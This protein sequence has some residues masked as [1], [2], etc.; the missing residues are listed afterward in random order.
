MTS[1]F[2]RSDVQSV[3]EKNK[4]STLRQIRRD[5]EKKLCLGEGDLDPYKDDI[6]SIILSLLEEDTATDKA[7]NEKLSPKTAK[8]DE[9]SS[10]NSVVEGKGRGEE[11]AEFNKSKK[12]KVV[13]AQDKPFK[14]KKKR[15]Y[16][17]SEDEEPRKSKHSKQKKSVQP[18]VE[19][20]QIH[21][22]PT[23]KKLKA[24]AKKATIP[25]PPN[26]FKSWKQHGADATTAA[27]ELGE[28]LAEKAG[29]GGQD[30]LAL[31]ERKISNIRNR[32]ERERD[33][34][35]IDTTNIL[36]GS[37]RRTSKFSVEAIHEKGSESEGSGN[38]GVDS[39]SDSEQNLV[40]LFPDAD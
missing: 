7:K 13:G 15:I 35:D 25:I 11:G 33:L 6:K 23:I 2:K 17:D 14:K 40:E 37:R 8:C 12:R 39:G 3:Y 1:L 4:Q 9:T 22:D 26:V 20:S 5:L 24:F 28:Y 32:L 30:P 31:D 34:M 18:T 19:R 29:L 38:S 36:N 27:E 10:A 16:S 21:D